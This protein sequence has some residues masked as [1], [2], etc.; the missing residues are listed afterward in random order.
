V[1]CSTRPWTRSSSS[2]TTDDRGV[3]RAA[4]QLFGYTPA[5]IVGRNVRELMPDP[6]GASTTLHAPVHDTGERG[7]SAPAAK[8]GRSART[9]VSSRAIF[10]WATCGESIRRA[11]S[12]SSAT[13]RRASRPTSGCAAARR[14]A[15]RAEA[16]QPGQLRD[17]P[18]RRYGGLLFATA[19]PDPGVEE[20]ERRIVRDEYLEKWCI[21]RTASACPRRS[22]AWTP[23]R[24][25]STS[26]TRSCSRTAA[27]STCTTSRQ[28]MLGPTARS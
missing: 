24:R 21:R 15:A 12:A 4:Q 20:S 19:A 18:G 2:T 22:R 25:R 26:S 27:S 14:A 8:S 7:S 9:A 10:P 3:Q 1:L 13:S 28:A 5:E 11:S 16:G 6:Y 17:A 23:D